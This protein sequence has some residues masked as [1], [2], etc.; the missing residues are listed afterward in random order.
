MKIDEQHSA[1]P[2]MRALVQHSRRGP[3]DLVLTTD[4]RRP[5]PGRPVARYRADNL[6]CVKK[7][8]RHPGRRRLARAW[9][10]K[11]TSQRS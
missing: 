6:P 8:R 4:H 9:P 11:R 5:T 1:G 3:Q 2:S 10:R 7:G